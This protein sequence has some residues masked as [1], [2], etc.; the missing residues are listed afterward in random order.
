[1]E[2]RADRLH[3]GVE[4]AGATKAEHAVPIDRTMG[5]PPRDLQALVDAGVVREAAANGY[6]VYPKQLRAQPLTREQRLI[7]AMDAREA[8]AVVPRP[9]TWERLM[10][11][12]LFWIII[13]LIPMLM[14][15]M[16]G[17]KR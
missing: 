3:A 7:Q 5:L 4:A 6:Y 1:M 11:T 10:K 17:R 13:I 9:F 14:I 16:L 2:R 15:Q 12:V 8:A